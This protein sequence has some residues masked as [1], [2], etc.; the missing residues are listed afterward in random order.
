VLLLQ[1]VAVAQPGKSQA[2]A[3]VQVLRFLASKTET[4]ID[5]KLADHIQRVIATPEGGELVEYVLDLMARR[6]GI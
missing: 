1:Q 6:G 3:V 5:D 4:D 2:A